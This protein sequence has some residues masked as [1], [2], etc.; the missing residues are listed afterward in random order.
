MS[1]LS[2][3]VITPKEFKSELQKIMPGYKWTVHRCSAPYDYMSAIG[4][5]SRGSNRLSTVSVIR[6]QHEDQVTYEV[7]SAGYG[8]KAKWLYECTENTIAKALRSL[9]N[10]YESMCA[11]YRSHADDL[12]QGREH[13]FSKCEQ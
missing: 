9:Q 4:T 1:K 13:N 3:Q 10:H 7:K 2:T 5:Q 11:L 8:L 12:Q 6:R